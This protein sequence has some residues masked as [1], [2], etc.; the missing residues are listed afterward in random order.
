[1]TLK[2]KISNFWYYYKNYLFAGII[3]IVVLV[4]CINSCKSRRNFDVNV[5]FMTHG[6][7][8]G[9]Y[10][11]DEL[12]AL[13]DKYVQDVNG[14]GVANTQF[15]TIYYGTTVQQHNSANATRS[16]NLAAGKNVLF[17]VDEQNYNEL[18][19]GGF[20]ADISSLGNSPYLIGDRF[21]IYNSG[22]FETL[23]GSNMLSDQYYLC[24]RTL[25]KTK[26]ENDS[27]YVA[28]YEAAKTLLKN[29]I[30]AHG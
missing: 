21:E 30:K 24:L 13:F 22:M 14:D 6:G 18:K 11:T 25:D 19:G 10:E 16:A 9:Y 15:I 20:L 2:Q 27:S 26:A 28:Q 4:V 29:I 5:L 23:T 1:M 8:N 17:L 12:S 7:E 3:A